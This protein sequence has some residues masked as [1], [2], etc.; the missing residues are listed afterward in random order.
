M[1][2]HYISFQKWENGRRTIRLMFVIPVE[3]RQE[4]RLIAAHEMRNTKGYRY[5]GCD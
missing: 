2:N 3:T 4:A 5:A 1:T